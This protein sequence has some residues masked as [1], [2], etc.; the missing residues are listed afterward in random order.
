MNSSTQKLMRDVFVFRTTFL[1]FVF[2]GLGDCHKFHCS[3]NTEWPYDKSPTC[4]G[5]HHHALLIPRPGIGASLL[6]TGIIYS[7]SR[8]LFFFCVSLLSFFNLASGV[9]SVSQSHFSFSPSLNLQRI[10]VRPTKNFSFFF[11]FLTHLLFFFIQ[12]QFEFASLV[13]AGIQQPPSLLTERI[14]K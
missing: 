5:C 4:S 11:F 7:I 8:V 2:V 13:P 10:K 12:T 3:A 1:S 9:T 6:A 14:N